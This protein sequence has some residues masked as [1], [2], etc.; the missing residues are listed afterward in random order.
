MSKLLDMIIKVGVDEALDRLL[1]VGVM[2]KKIRQ[3]DV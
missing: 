3:V 2:D 1:N